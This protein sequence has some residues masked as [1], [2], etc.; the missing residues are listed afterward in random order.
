M[1]PNEEPYYFVINIARDRDLYSHG[2]VELRAASSIERRGTQLR[3][4]SL[5]MSIGNNISTQTHHIP[6]TR[7]EG[8]VFLLSMDID[9]PDYEYYMVEATLEME[10]PIEATIKELNTGETARHCPVLSTETTT[11]SSGSRLLHRLF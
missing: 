6:D 11:L 7:Y 5:H 3:E 9:M 8:G 4:L 2:W 10:F 1:M